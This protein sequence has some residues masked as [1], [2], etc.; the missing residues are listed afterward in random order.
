MTGRSNAENRQV[1][2]AEISRNLKLLARELECPVVALAQLNRGLEQRADKRP[3]LSDLR[4]SGCLTASTRLLR[5]DTGAE[6]TLGELVETGA[7]DVPVWSLDDRWRLVPATLTRAFPSGTKPVFRMRLASGRVVEATANHR[8]RT[9]D[10]WTPLGDLTEGSRIA[11]P[12]RLDVPDE[13][14]T[15][16]SDELVLLAERSHEKFVPDLVFGA[17][18]EQVRTFLHHLWAT[19]GTIVLNRTGRGP[20]VRI[21][22]ATTSRRLADDVQRLLLRCGVQSRISV[23]AQ[24]AHRPSHHVR[25]E[26]VDHQRRFLTDIGAHGQRGLRVEPALDLLDGVVTNPNV[27]TIPYDV[28]PLVVEALADAGLSQRDLASELGE[29]YCGSYLL[30]SPKR[31]RSMRRARLASIAEITG[32]KALADLARSDVLW[33]RVVEIESIGE[34]PVFDATVLGTH[35]FVADGIV[36]HNSLEQDADVVMFLF[37]EEVYEPTPENAGLAEVIIAK[38][39]NGPIGTARLSFLG[40]FTRFESMPRD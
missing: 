34:H 35:T 10:G 8:F 6:V 23:V 27:D 5:A 7:R 18:T 12:R 14:T 28:R 26:G 13:V 1:E 21:A 17:P 19:D 2:V 22:Y 36:A 39:R 33:D 40:H 38:Q 24:G 3:V 15:L 9:I 11:V 31:P 25:I 20:R 32:S 4:E 30:G 16:D 37:R 29:A